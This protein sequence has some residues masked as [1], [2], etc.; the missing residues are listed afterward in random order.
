MGDIMLDRSS[1]VKGNR[2]AN[3]PPALRPAPLDHRK[4][5]DYSPAF[6][7]RARVTI[8]AG[9]RCADGIMV[10]S[11]TEHTHGEIQK[12][13]GAK[14]FA[15]RH[16]AGAC[17]ILAFAGSVPYAKMFIEMAQADFYG[18]GE[19]TAA[20]IKKKLFSG[21]LD[22]HKKYIFPHPCFRLSGGPD[23]QLIV[24]IRDEGRDLHLL[25]T[26]EASLTPVQGVECI[27]IGE[28]LF[29]YLSRERVFPSMEME[30][31]K[32]Q[33]AEMMAEVKR[34]V[35]GCGGKTHFMMLG[36]SLLGESV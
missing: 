15:F 2:M 14:M 32:T 30:K 22:F 24:A 29:R 16:D 27:G 23:F 5:R 31:A 19:K 1:I 3:M 10:C 4:Q 21:L 12:S 18:L 20:A 6:R 35:P 17:L 25:S 11:D 28:N 13:Y 36:T 34:Y 26:Y 33:A 7:R 8:A 9:F